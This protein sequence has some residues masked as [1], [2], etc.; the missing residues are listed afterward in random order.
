MSCTLSWSENKTEAW[1]ST[2]VDESGE[3]ISGHEGFCE[4]ACQPKKL[5]ED[6]N[7]EP[8]IIGKGSSTAQ[9]N[10]NC[11]CD[12]LQVSKSDEIT[13]FTKQSGEINGRSYY[14]SITD[15]KDSG[16]RYQENIVWWNDT[17]GSWI[18][19]VYV[20]SNKSLITNLEVK[21][22]IHCP[23]FHKSLAEH[24]QANNG[25]IKS[26]CLTD[27]NKCHLKKGEFDVNQSF[28]FF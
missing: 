15:S 7:E 3:H 22:D 9:E 19:Q 11:E 23:N 5:T 26:K 1:C 4:P 20:P 12:I 25:Y 6:T 28:F 24:Q 2:K 8:K 16:S 17:A 14:F 13:N 18:F 27:K 21:K 10:E